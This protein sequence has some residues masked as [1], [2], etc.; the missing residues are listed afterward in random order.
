MKILKIAAQV[1]LAPVLAL[2]MG[3]AVFAEEVALESF[4]VYVKTDQGYLP[5]DVYTHYRMDFEY[6]GELPVLTPS[7]NGLEVV[8]YQPDLSPDYLSFETRPLD[9]PGLRISATP[10]ISP[11]SDNQYRITFKED[12]PS[13]RIL[14]VGTGWG[15]NSVYAVSLSSPLAG[16]IEGYKEGSDITATNATWSLDK[17]LVAYPG[18]KRLIE[19]QAHWTKKEVEAKATEQYDWVM[20]AWADY[21]KA[22]TSESKVDALENVKGRI[23]Y[24]FKEFPTG[25]ETGELEDLLTTVEGKLRL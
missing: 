15:E 16:F 10:K 23:E 19:L 7:S 14:M 1:A 21:E 11:L 3:S 13:D 9:S 24:Y 20:T 12:I 17:I 4:G 18:N 6:F 2:S 8:V 25:M 5:A 22:K